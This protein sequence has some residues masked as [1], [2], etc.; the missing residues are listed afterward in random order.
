MAR[1]GGR[2]SKVPNNHLSTTACQANN[3]GMMAWDINSYSHVQPPET[4]WV[5][6][7]LGFKCVRV[8]F[9]SQQ[10]QSVKRSFPCGTKHGRH[11]SLIQSSKTISHQ[12][13][14]VKQTIR[15]WPRTLIHIHTCNITEAH[16]SKW[17]WF[18]NTL[19]WNMVLN[20]FIVSKDKIHVGLNMAL[21]N[22]IMTH[23]K[24]LPEGNFLDV[25]AWYSKSWMVGTFN[26][27]N[28]ESQF[29]IISRS[30]YEKKNIAILFWTRKQWQIMNMLQKWI[31]V[32]L[33]KVCGCYLVT[34]S[35][36]PSSIAHVYIPELVWH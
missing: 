14:H 13:R 15:R 32:A 11:G 26:I 8:E 4:A 19:K 21:I 34:F 6:I 5:Q 35:C 28:W 36:S 17:S 20:N 27:S 29:P 24:V 33:L 7:K 22:M 25:G 23:A 1:A 31:R 16:R 30:S 3:L 9:D 2:W 10:F 18:T 12:Q